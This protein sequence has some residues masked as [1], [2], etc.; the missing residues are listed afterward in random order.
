MPYGFNDDKSM[1][2]LS[3]IDQS[4]EGNFTVNPATSGNRI[5]NADID[6][7]AEGRIG[8]VSGSFTPRYTYSSDFWLLVGTTDILPAAETGGTCGSTAV[9]TSNMI[10]IDNDGKVYMRM[11]NSTLNG[12]AVSFSLPY[13]TAE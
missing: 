1:F 11:I 8:C 7:W 4:T 12:V 13:V 10:K 2:D 6:S 3:D 5:T 9:G